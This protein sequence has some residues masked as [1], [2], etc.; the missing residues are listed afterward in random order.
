MEQAWQLLVS[1]NGSILHKH[2]PSQ[3]TT[4][5]TYYNSSIFYCSPDVAGIAAAIRHAHPRW[6]PAQVRDSI[7]NTAYVLSSGNFYLATIDGVDCQATPEPTSN[8]TR[9]PTRNP[10]H[11]PTNPIRTPTR[12]A[13]TSKPS[14]TKRGNNTTKKNPKAQK[15]S[16]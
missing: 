15:N 6:T 2:A 7:V 8:P 4:H 5:L 10:T 16:P 9:N 14:P 13:P 1:L 11:N 12:S 3:S